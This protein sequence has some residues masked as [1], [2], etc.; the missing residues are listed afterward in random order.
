MFGSAPAGAFV[1]PFLSAYRAEVFHD[2]GMKTLEG[3]VFS[4]GLQGGYTHLVGRWVFSGGV[5][6]SYGL[7]TAEAPAGSPRAEQLPHQGLWVNFRLNAG[8]AF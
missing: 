3:Y 5:G 1:G 7:A 4:P 6:L 2:D 8:L